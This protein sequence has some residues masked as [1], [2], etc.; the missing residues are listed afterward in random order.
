MREK[1]SVIVQ[2][3]YGFGLLVNVAAFY[4]INDWKLIFWLCYFT[5]GLLV[6]L[7]LVFFVRDTP[8]CLVMRQTSEKAVAN[9]AFIAKINGISESEMQINTGTINGIKY[10]CSIRENKKEKVT[11]SL[12]DLFRYNSLRGMTLIL[13]CLQST[14]IFEFYAPALMIDQFKLNI[15]ING[16]VVAVSEIVAYPLCYCLITCCKRKHV[17]YVC[18]I[19]SFICSFALIFLWNDDVNI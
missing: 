17:A 16:I 3:F 18:F 6:F 1:C 13:I 9:F 15:F 10:D 7:S 8:I 2:L 12:C 11:F 14:V 5:P 19:V 4:W